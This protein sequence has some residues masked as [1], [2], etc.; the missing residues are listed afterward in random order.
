MSLSPEHFYDLWAKFAES[1]IIQEL[2][3]DVEKFC[4]DAEITVD[5]FIAE[6]M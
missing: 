4:E 6:F 2:P 1:K 3:E 5:Y